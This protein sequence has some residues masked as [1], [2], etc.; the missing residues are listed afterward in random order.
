MAKRIHI[1]KALS[2]Y[3]RATR[4]GKKP[5]EVRLNDRDYRIGD[6]LKIRE[7]DEQGYFLGRTIICRINYILNLDVLAGLEDS[8]YVVLGLEDFIM[9]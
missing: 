8:N 9:P 7:S 4:N 6:M 5:F 3:F 1:I 2:Q